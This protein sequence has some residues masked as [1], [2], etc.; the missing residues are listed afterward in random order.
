MIGVHRTT[1]LVDHR[2]AACLIEQIIRLWVGEQTQL[3]SAN[4][5]CESILTQ[6]YSFANQTDKQREYHSGEDDGT[7]SRRIKYLPVDGRG[8][9]VV[10]VVV[11]L[12][13][14]LEVAL[15]L[16][17]LLVRRLV[18]GALLILALF[19]I[20]LFVRLLVAGL[21]RRV[22]RGLYFRFLRDFLV[23]TGVRRRVVPAAVSV[24]APTR[25]G[26]A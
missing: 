2:S 6:K 15:L 8:L 1:N 22:R 9:L 13:A 7:H 4:T 26:P 16:V 19:V 23:V 20:A 24:V 25:V 3:C 21:L 12:I 11:I 5:R 17:V 10:S 18:V 14:A